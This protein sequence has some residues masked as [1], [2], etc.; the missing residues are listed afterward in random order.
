MGHAKSRDVRGRFPNFVFLV[1]F[2]SP[3][4]LPAIYHGGTQW[5]ISVTVVCPSDEGFAPNGRVHMPGLRL[6]WKRLYNFGLKSL[7]TLVLCNL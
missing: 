4:H 6:S 5:F 3:H 1:A 7:V 2:F